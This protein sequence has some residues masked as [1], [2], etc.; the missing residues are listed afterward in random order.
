MDIPTK[1]DDYREQSRKYY[2]AYG[3]VNPLTSQ[4][5]SSVEIIASQQQKKL[6]ENI[7]KL[8]QKQYTNLK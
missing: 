8:L 1:A 4:E 7:T 6:S 5:M 2:Q 3:I